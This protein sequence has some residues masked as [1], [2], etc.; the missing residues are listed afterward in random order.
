MLIYITE[1]IPEEEFMEIG[2]QTKFCTNQRCHEK[3]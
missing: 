3:R 1:K 2:L